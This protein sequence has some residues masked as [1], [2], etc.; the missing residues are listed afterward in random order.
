[1]EVDL[2]VLDSLQRAA[3]VRHW[4]RHGAEIVAAWTRNQFASDRL[5]R[6]GIADTMDAPRSD[7]ARCFVRPLFDLLVA[8]LETG[9]ARYRQV[10][11]EARTRYAPQRVMPS[12]RAAF[13][14]EV[15][16]GDEA[17]LAAR[18]P[19]GALRVALAAAITALHEPLRRRP[20]SADVRLLTLGGRLMNEV[21]VFLAD[22]CRA[23]GTPLQVTASDLTADMWNGDLASG[24]RQVL[25]T[26]SPDVIA[27]SFLM[28]AGSP[29]YEALRAMAGRV[30][31]AERD[32]CI[33]ALIGTTRTF[34]E[35]VR[36]LTDAPILLHNAGGLPLGR[37]RRLM[38]LLP[39]HSSAERQMLDALNGAIGDL[40]ANVPN[41][42]LI[43]EASIVQQHGA[44]QVTRPVIPRRISR[45]A[46]LNASR[47]GALLA[48]EYASVLR[49]YRDLHRAKVLALD[50]DG[51]LWRG[52]MTDGPVEHRHDLQSLL[53]E[54]REN[55]VLL[56][57][58]SMNDAA[59]I[60]WD[61]MTLQPDDFAF[62]RVNGTR[63]ARSIREAAE[64][65]GLGLEA[66][67]LIDDDPAERAIVTSQLPM[68]HAMD[69]GADSTLTALRH[70]LAFPNTK[71]TGDARARAAMYRQQAQRREAMSAE[72][73]YPSTMR[74]LELVATTQP[75]TMG[76]LDRIAELVQQA[77][78]F[79]TTTIRYTR[80]RLKEMLGDPRH[81]ISVTRVA[82]KFGDM[83]I[84]GV[85]IVKSR[86]GDPV[87]DTFVMSRHTMGFDLERLML[88]SVV[89][90]H[91]G[92]A[93]IGRF[94]PSARNEAAAMLY[95]SNGFVQR[96]ATEWVLDP[97]A[98]RPVAPA[99]FSLGHG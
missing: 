40:A 59:T 66:F 6:Y 84:V 93:V 55:G 35:T 98:P 34:I 89:E 74:T 26:H 57:G 2:G 56:V 39:A 22:E 10:Y 30:S 81:W 15:L 27:T 65:I 14:E 99:W 11:L 76:D 7:L 8:H 95:P 83:G 91:G 72:L 60:R 90:R 21:R 24:L 42:V 71:P 50:F 73:D 44:R 77:S 17:A 38:P 32:R 36:G 94:V 33:H 97:H 37:A 52:V 19:E 12:V 80:H 3:L 13:F 75:A 96:D 43:D 20:M 64:A 69:A 4:R 63:K 58:I 29:Q 79:N 18:L 47:L 85:T 48:R 67:V 53:R 28:F 70:M 87:I 5:A 16:P 61:E 86:N 9:E 82:D 88:A 62:L 41:V 54:L 92:R 49:A 31:A 45:R 23:V 68:V 78:R 51:T 1:M 46:E 25:D